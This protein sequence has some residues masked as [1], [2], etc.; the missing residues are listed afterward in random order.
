MNK[1]ILGLIIIFLAVLS[2]YTIETFATIPAFTN[3]II[4][5]ED[6]KE[7]EDIYLGGYNEG[8]DEDDYSS[9]CPIYN[10]DANGCCKDNKEL[11][12]CEKCC[13]SGNQCKVDGEI[14]KP[15]ICPIDNRYDNNGCCKLS[16][17]KNCSECCE[18]GITCKDYSKCRTEYCEKDNRDDNGCCTGIQELENCERCC[19][20]GI[21]CRKDV[22]L[23][24]SRL[25]KKTIQALN[26]ARIAS[27]PYQITFETD[28]TQYDNN[29]FSINNLKAFR[30]KCKS[31][32]LN[33]NYPKNFT[34][35]LIGYN[36]AY[37]DLPGRTRGICQVI[38]HYNEE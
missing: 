24:P 5:V 11:E 6:D 12:D 30:D 33:Y 16:F 8:E 27:D 9:F 32:L 20:N 15:T 26:F 35:K 37:S 4:R 3:N 38:P 31:D 17:L 13:P 2:T 34:S 25:R 36:S 10:R 19:P 1:I 21:T 18:D 23:C 28:E 7:S 22:L 14:C 29:L